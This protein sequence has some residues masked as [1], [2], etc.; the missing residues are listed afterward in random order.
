[1]ISRSVN[2]RE[3]NAFNAKKMENL[4]K[5]TSQ[6]WPYERIRDKTKF[7]L[8]KEH[9][10]FGFESLGLRLR[11]EEKILVIKKKKEEERRE[12]KKIKVW[13]LNLKPFLMMLRFGENTNF[14]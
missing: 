14:T 9:L 1:M 8:I 12:K 5:M 13:K 2:E 3:R 6:T 4:T 11:E 10:S 7:G